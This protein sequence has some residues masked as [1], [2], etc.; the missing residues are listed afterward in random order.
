MLYQTEN[1]MTTTAIDDRDVQHGVVVAGPS[2]TLTI[3]GIIVSEIVSAI[4]MTTPVLRIEADLGAH[5]TVRLDRAP[6]LAA[7]HV[8]HSNANVVRHKAP[9]G[10]RT[11]KSAFRFW[12]GPEVHTAIAY[13]WPGIDNSWIRQFVDVA[14]AAG[15]STTVICASL[16]ESNQAR[17][18]TLVDTIY[19]ADLVIV[20]DASEA[21]ELAS[22]FG[23]SGPSV[24]SLRAL[25]LGGRSGR[26]P[27]GV[28][29]AFLQKE[30]IN[31]LAVL[32]AAFD[33]IPD[34]RISGHKLQVVMRFASREVLSIVA[35]SYHA[36]H[37][38]LIGD[39]ISSS[40][41]QELCD[42]SS[43]L[44]MADPVHDSRA[45]STAMDCGIATVVLANS[46]RPP[47]GRGYVGGLLA[48]HSQ[49]AS[50]HV[51]LS[52]ALR[53]SDLGFPSP[54]AWCELADRLGATQND[55]NRADAVVSPRSRDNVNLKRSLEAVRFLESTT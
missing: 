35:N 48:N 15:A 45:F 17:A 13:A 12:I 41:L 46:K 6:S 18:V 8:A 39:D 5:P 26:A 9:M 55:T 3:P 30:D 31:S 53:L 37:V 52:H 50:V 11:R 29:T 2:S 16:P 10:A 24:E 20:G 22:M 32:L 38:E 36:S 7:A 51:A 19:K 21:K 44:S 23:S 47:V 33:A 1:E 40:D 49:P 28:I 43:A 14:K 25:S 34:A 4:A 27:R 54:T 42:L